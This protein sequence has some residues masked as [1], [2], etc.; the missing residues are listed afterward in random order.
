MAANNFYLGMTIA[1]AHNVNI[2]NIVG[3]IS[4]NAGPAQS[5]AADIEIRI[6]TDTGTG[7]NGMNRKTVVQGLYLAIEYVNSMGPDHAGTYLPKS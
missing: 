7:D 6:Q 2:G 1:Q 4:T 3:T 5:T